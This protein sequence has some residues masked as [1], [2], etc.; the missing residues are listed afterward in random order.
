MSQN[1]LDSQ[2]LPKEPFLM[3]PNESFKNSCL[4]VPIL[5]NLSCVKVSMRQKCSGDPCGTLSGGQVCQVHTSQMFL[6]TLIVSLQLH[7]KVLS[8][9]S[10]VSTSPEYR[11][12][13]MYQIISTYCLFSTSHSAFFSYRSLSLSQKSQFVRPT[14]FANTSLKCR[15]PLQSSSLSKACLKHPKSKNLLKA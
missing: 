6:D 14:P 11:A 4:N 3:I 12:F 5:P 13:R 10:N 8:Q 9:V 15:N 7:S 1:Y 2:S